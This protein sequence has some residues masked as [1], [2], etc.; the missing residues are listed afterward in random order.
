MQKC[1]RQPA[2]FI[3]AACFSCK[4][5]MDARSHTTCQVSEAVGIISPRP[6]EAGQ[7]IRPPLHHRPSP[8]HVVHL[9]EDLAAHLTR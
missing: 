5:K 3:S 8:S 6:F 1:T 2:A 4:D 7:A 9:T